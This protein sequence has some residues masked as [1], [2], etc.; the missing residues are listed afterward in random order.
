MIATIPTTEALALLSNE[1]QLRGLG[2][3]V[4]DT[5]PAK[6]TSPNYPALLSSVRQNGITTPVH[7]RDSRHGRFL[8][9]GHHRITA[10]L[11]AGL[12]QIPWT[13]NATLAD[14]IDSMSWQLTLGTIT[15]AAV[16]AFTRG[17]CAGLA[18]ALHDTTGWPLVEV[19]HCDGLPFHFTVRHPDGL[20]VDILGTRTE[21]DVAEEYE[22]DADGDVVTFTETDR[23]L[24]WRCYL[25][26]CG[27]PVPMDVARTFVPAVLALVQ[28]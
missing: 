14:R 22:Y 18:L 17:A 9:E 19:G 28:Q 8:V 12:T 15:P 7:I 25:E 4:E 16:E 3:T 2:C 1:A 11:D 21:E 10:A 5:A 26:D 24:V 23:A 27:E 13:D 6:R 20:L